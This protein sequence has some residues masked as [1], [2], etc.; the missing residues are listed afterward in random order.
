MTDDAQHRAAP[1]PGCTQPT[2]VFESSRGLVR[3]AGNVV[4]AWLRLHR[5]LT[6]AFELAC[7][8]A[9]EYTVDVGFAENGV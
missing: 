7:P 5:V 3:L 1:L 2:G 6:D 8:G 9:F 4:P